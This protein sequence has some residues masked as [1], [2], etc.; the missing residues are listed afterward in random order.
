VGQ[1]DLRSVRCCSEPALNIAEGTGFRFAI[2]D[3]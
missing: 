2:Y 3:L 1:T